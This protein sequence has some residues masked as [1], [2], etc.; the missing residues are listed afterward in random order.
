VTDSSEAA[1]RR[2]ILEAAEQLLRH[3]GPGKTTIADIAREAKV[4]VGSVYLVFPS[5]EAI[6]EE[7]SNR[8]HGAVLHAMRDAATDCGCFEER[9]RAIVS[10][11]VAAYLGL[12][13]EGAHA[14][15]LV[16]CVSPAVR[17]AQARFHADELTFIAELLRAATRA[18]EFDVRDPDATALAILR[19]YSTFAPPFLFAQPRDEVAAGLEAMHDLVLFGLLGRKEAR[20]RVSS[21]ARAAGRKTLLHPTAK[22]AAAPRKRKPYP[23]HGL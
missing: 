12:C 1:R 15:D 2:Q 14:R 16:H 13:D 18:G 17:T 11:R 3:Y 9:I 22:T 7:L 8:R 4:G 21:V 23:R 6:I 5:K 20:S 19:A 10:A